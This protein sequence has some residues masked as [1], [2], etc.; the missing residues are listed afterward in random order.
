MT[1][2]SCSTC[3]YHEAVRRDLGE[4][5][6]MPPVFRVGLDRQYRP[7]VQ[8][9]DWCGQWKAKTAE[10]AESLEGVI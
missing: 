5:R 6:F 7:Q 8:P 3:D 10:P 4:C 9:T 1:A 2:R